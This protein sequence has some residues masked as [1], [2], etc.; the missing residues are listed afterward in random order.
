MRPS[1]LFAAALTLAS[2]AAAPAL[3]REDQPAFRTAAHLHRGVNIVSNDPLWTD[4]AKARFK[5]RH[6]RIIRQGGFDFVRVVLQAFKHMDAQNRLDPRWLATL[7]HVVGQATAA[8]LD[9]IVDEHDFNTCAN[10]AA[11]CE[12]KLVAFWQQVGRRY[13]DA[14][15][16]V[17][18]ELL[19]EPH[20]QLNGEPWNLLLAKLIP[21]VRAT[22]PGRTLLIGPSHW[23]SLADL[24]LLKLPE[25]DRNIIVEF[26]YYEPFR[27]THQGASWT[28]NKDLH[29]IPFTPQDQAR[30]RADFDKVAAWSRANRRPVLLGEFGAYDGGGT[31]VEDRARYDATVRGEAEAHGFPWAYWQ[32]DGDFIVYDIDH[33]HWIEPLH[34]A[35]IP[36][37]R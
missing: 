26:H 11:G 32:F 37:A 1:R 4:P 28:D 9:V 17:Q 21:A 22:N 33:D 23:N 5:D 20:G 35:L 12:T 8:G 3:A 6:F 7:D 36:G 24:P 29:G 27:F 25:G 2:C 30:I 34:K 14:P 18:F 15:A 31:P 19:N 13:R 16:S 10:D